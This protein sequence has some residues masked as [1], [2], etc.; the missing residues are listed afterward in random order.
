MKLST[1][2]CVLS[3]SFLLTN[4]WVAE[5][6]IGQD[7][8]DKPVRVATFDIDATPPLGSAMAYDPVKRLD[9]LTLR[10]RGVVLL[11]AE[12]PI[13]LCAVDWIGIANEGHDAFRDALAQAA[14]TT[15]QRVAVHTLHQHDAPGCD[16]TAERIVRELGV[17]GFDRFDGSFHRQVISRAADAVRAAV[18]VAQPVTHYGWGEATVQGVASNRRILGPDGRV[19]AV[20]YTAT[21]DPAL[22]A[23]PDGVI[24]PQVS[25]LSFWN[26]DQ[27]LAVLSYYAC[28]PQSYYRTGVPSPDFP[29]IARFIRGQAVPEALHVHFNGAGGNIGA[30]KYNDGNKENRLLLATRLAEGMKQAWLAT[31]KTGLT[32]ADLGW[33]T[34][35]VKL[36]LAEHLKRAELVESLK[37]EPARGYVSK[38]DQLAWLQR[39]E[40]GHKLDIACLRVG[41]VRVLHMPGELF[42][43]YQLAAKALR[44]DLHVAMAAYGDYG[45]GYI[46]TTA[47]YSEGGY[48]T[49]ANASNVAP[50]VEATLIQATKKLLQEDD[51]QA[52]NL[53]VQ[54]V[55][56]EEAVK[57][58]E[59]QPGYEMQLVASEPQIVEPVAL[60]YDE[61]GKLFV[62]EY[63]KFPATDGHSD[64]PDGCIRRLE[65]R[66]GDG[67]YEHSQIFADSLA[68]PTGICPWDGG[69]FVVASPDLWYFKDT[70]G[71]G[72]ADVRRKLFTGFGFTTEE[73]TANNLIW[74]LDNWIYGAGSSSGGEVKSVEDPAAAPVAMRGRDFRF[75]P[76]TGKFEAISG[77]EQFGNS[78]DDWG[79]RFICQNSKPAV[80]VVLPSHYLARNPYLPVT[81][82]LHN[83]WKDTTVYRASAPEAWRLARTKL[84][85]SERPDWTGPSVAHDVFTACTGIC[86]FRGTAYPS[87]VRGSLL[88]GDVQSNIIHRRSLHP[89][90]ATFTSERSEPKTEFVRSKD[91]WFRPTNIINA[92]DGTLHIA[93]MYREVI[94]TPDSMPEPIRAMVDLQSG[95]DRGRIYRLAPTGFKPPPSPQ[96]GS[97]TTAELVRVLENENGWWRDTAS[98]LIYQRQDQAACDG[99]RT[100]LRTSSSELAQLHAMY[101]LDGLQD[102]TD[103][104]LLHALASRSAGVREH[105]VRLA[106][107]H[108]QSPASQA[109]QP[110]A[111]EQAVIALADDPNDRVRFQVAFSMGEC[112]QP[113]AADALAQLARRDADN[114]WMRTAILSSSVDLASGML[115]AL[116][117]DGDFTSKGSSQEL[118]RQLSLILGGRNQ[119]AE[120]TGILNR[121]DQLSPA[122]SQDARRSILLGLSEGLRRSGASMSRYLEVSP[123]AQRIFGELLASAKQTLANDTSSIAQRQRA[124]EMLS[125]AHL[126]DVE[127]VLVP[128]LDS[129]QPPAIQLT[130]IQALGRMDDDSV[131][132]ALIDGWPGLSPSVR[133][134]V[135]ESLLSRRSWMGSLLDAIEQKRI[136]FSYIAP[137]RQTQLLQHADPAIRQRMQDLL[138]A[139]QLGTRKDVV[140]RYRSALDMTGD[141]TRGQAVYQKNCM[142]C[143]K[144]RDQGHEV[145]P[146]LATIQNRT[147]DALMVQILD[148]NHEVLANYTQYIIMQDD[149]RVVTG[150]IASE[151]PTSLTIKRAENVQD[152][153]LRQNIEEII[154]TGKSLMPEGLE[155]N[156]TPQQMSDLLAYLLQLPQ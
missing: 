117:S 140:Q 122:K 30:G 110:S 48:E 10:C 75:H 124:I 152:V 89:Q 100:L 54:P 111:L 145:G 14:G 72:R 2:T 37:S 90:G 69:I 40:S 52:N 23:E 131:A 144:V 62:A 115:E 113:A 80:H 93:D 57:R 156:I 76:V 87:D 21:K 95:H 88:L 96:L 33:Q 107:S 43:E 29:G 155:Q 8:A 132:A 44:P 20:R 27:P 94:E 31:K 149:G 58:F 112:D 128:L 119:A 146:N 53:R 130:A 36:P 154:G 86:V 12:E 46:G 66:D 3:I 134:E 65:D 15:R 136:P 28:H 127:A 51:Q 104:D 83:T 24:D 56:A 142:A 101:A 63:L 38:A 121:I 13:V 67:H 126:K 61:N 11:G 138:N 19:R 98:R 22:R 91:N 103:D 151:S 102:L 81:S 17:A 137:V 1:I 25:L 9:E 148:P 141:V 129:R 118:L 123:A 39:C 143:H 105:A 147:P 78:F 109:I 64:G 45:P 97:A 60:A 35:A 4:A 49:G 32:V 125:H 16:F 50:S 68:W 42:V 41:D 70:D 5:Y 108:F 47:A 77:S 106:E 34:E 82:V 55:E 74:G 7:H 79:N 84:R 59:L 133:G 150:L 120:I 26:Q 153:V 116:L 73:G 71:D 135:V 99:L 139:N 18:L 92:P 114:V 85:L 6:S